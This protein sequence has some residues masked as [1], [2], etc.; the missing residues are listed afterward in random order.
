MPDSEKKTEAPKSQKPKANSE[1][2]AAEIYHELVHVNTTGW[3]E[4]Q[5]VEHKAKCAEAYAAKRKT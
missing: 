1:P 2:T 3:P 5:I 4:K